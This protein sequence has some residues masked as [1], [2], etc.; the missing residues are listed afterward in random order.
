[1]DGDELVSIILRRQFLATTQAV[2]GVHEGKLNL[3]VRNETITFNIRKSMKSKY[4]RDDYLAEPV[5]PLEW[6]SLKNQL[7]PSSIKPPELEQKELPKHRKYAFL[8][9]NNQ[10]PVVISSALSTIEK[11]RLLEVLKNHKGAIAWSIAD[12]KGID[13]SFCNH[14]IL[15]EEEFKPSVQPQRRVNLNIKEVVKKEV[16][17]LLDAGLIYLISDSPWVSRVQVVP[18]KGGITVVK[19]EKNEL[20]P[21]RTVPDGAYASTIIN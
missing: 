3:R 9:K 17:K 18:K 11:A 1:M 21:Q 16:I 12:I 4:S 15:M 6:K 5:E 8:Q 7:K 19:N 10:L 20:I 14:K 2:I 13:S